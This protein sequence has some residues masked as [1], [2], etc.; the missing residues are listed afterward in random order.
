MLSWAPTHQPE[1]CDTLG[2]GLGNRFAEQG[3]AS[4]VLDGRLV[5]VA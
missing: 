5:V 3:S 4:S 1:F 2:G